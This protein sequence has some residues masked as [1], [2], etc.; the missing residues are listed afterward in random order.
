MR[1]IW[2]RAITGGVVAGVQRTNR[3]ATVPTRTPI[4]NLKNSLS[5]KKQKSIYAAA[6]APRTLPIAMDPITTCKLVD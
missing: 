1:W 6:S 3:F 2:N 4:L 5:P